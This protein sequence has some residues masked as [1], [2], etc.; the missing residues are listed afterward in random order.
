MDMSR[1]YITVL[2]IPFI[3]TLAA[4]LSPIQQSGDPLTPLEP[5][6]T[7]TATPT[8][9]WFPPTATYT[10]LP[11]STLPIT[12]TLETKP[13]HGKL[14]FTDEFANTS[15][16]ELGS[17]QDGII[18]L[19]ND[20]LSLVVKKERGY[21]SSIRQDTILDNFFAEITSGPRICRET[22]EYG[23]IFRVSTSNDFYRFSLTCDGHTR[24]D[25]FLNGQ[26]SSPQPLVIS[27]AI[28]PGAPSESRLAIWVHGSEMRFFVNGEYLFTVNDPTLSKGSIGVF[29]RANGED[30]VTISFSELAVYESIQ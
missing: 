30:D 23:F 20:E 6:A 5:T 27:G 29:A 7:Q 11:T 13:G 22:D 3:L 24:V 10:P 18:A 9:V 15:D 26:A 14:L 19:G 21:L 4:C 16:W 8:T 2:L 1:Y 12:P 28:P 25:R 17:F